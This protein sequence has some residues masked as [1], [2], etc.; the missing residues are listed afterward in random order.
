MQLDIPPGADAALCF[1]SDQFY[2]RYLDKDGGQQG[3]FLSPAAVHQAL[4]GEPIDSGW[5]P[6]GVSRWGTGS[7]GT[8]MLRYHEPAVYTFGLELKSRRRRL[9]VPMPALVFFGLGNAY[10]VWAMK[11]NKLDVKAALYR[12]P[13]SNT[14]NIGLICFGSNPHP[15]AG[16]GGFETAWKSFLE[17]PFNDHWTNGKSLRHP[18]DINA[19][20]IELHR[21]KATAYP[22]ADLVAAGGTLEQTIEKFTV[23]D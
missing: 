5:L 3:K 19:Q 8:W 13:V 1:I 12:A 18:N 4:K 23:R 9:R 16:K 17:A 21:S 6:A 10:Y 7:R 20:L 11:G 15:D 22:A 2:L 14:N